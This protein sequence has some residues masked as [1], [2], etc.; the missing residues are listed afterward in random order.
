MFSYFLP[1]DDIKPSLLIRCKVDKKKADYEEISYMDLRDLATNQFSTIVQ[2]IRSIH[3]K[4]E[5]L[6]NLYN[7]LNARMTKI[8]MLTE[9]TVDE[10]IGYYLTIFQNMDNDVH[11]IKKNLIED[12]GR[13]AALSMVKKIHAVIQHV[14]VE[15][16]LMDKIADVMHILEEVDND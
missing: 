12:L 4:I 13:N 7:D 8:E 15:D 11:A 10:L 1:D 6:G 5:S 2:E 16:E 9:T 14:T 3:E